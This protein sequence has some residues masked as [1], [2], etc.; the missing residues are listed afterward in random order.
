MSLPDVYQRW[1][2]G[3]MQTHGLR[4]DD[5]HPDLTAGGRNPAAIVA[6]RNTIDEVFNG[7]GRV[8]TSDEV[9][10]MLEL[11]AWGW[12]Y[13]EIAEA[14]DD[15]GYPNTEATVRTKMTRARSDAR[16]RLVDDA[17]E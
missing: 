6:A 14:L 15:A 9:R 1:H 8:V 4:L 3:E 10:A 7:D 17:R 13:E 12:S 2:R 5:R 16:R 11:Q